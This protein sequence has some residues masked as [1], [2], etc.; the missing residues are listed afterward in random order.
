MVYIPVDLMV[1]LLGKYVTISVKVPV[2][3][4]RKLERFG[5]KPSELLRRAIYEE[6]RKKEIMEIEKEL[7]ELKPVLNKF[8]KKFVVEAIRE[9]RESRRH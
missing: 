7:E 3:I 6:L 2:E 5:I 9:E 1:R 4:K 8:T